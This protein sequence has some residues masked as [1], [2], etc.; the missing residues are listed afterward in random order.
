VLSVLAR[1]SI[2]AWLAR[3]SRALQ[4]R[5]A[6][7]S[8][9]GSDRTLW[10][11]CSSHCAGEMSPGGGRRPRSVDFCWRQSS[12]TGLEDVLARRCFSPGTG[13]PAAGHCQR[14]RSAAVHLA[15][16]SSPGAKP[17]SRQRSSTTNQN[18]GFAAK[19]LHRR[20]GRQA[21]SSRHGR[22]RAERG[23]SRRKEAFEIFC[24]PP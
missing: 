8:D 16:R 12:I 9:T 17:C 7:K 14:C 21:L 23:A 6:L 10:R 2:F 13:P 1:D 11:P 3:V 20:S 5:Q 18:S 15:T 24:G 22:Q 4:L 19:S